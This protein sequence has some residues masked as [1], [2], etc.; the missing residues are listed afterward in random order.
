MRESTLALQFPHILCLGASFA[1]HHI[2]A[3]SVSL[4]QEPEPIHQDLGIVD[5]DIPVIHSSDKSIALVL[6]EPFYRTFHHSPS[7]LQNVEAAEPSS[8]TTADE[9]IK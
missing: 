9:R 5:K 8:Q 6:V 3:D 1:L 7:F 4:F 2:K